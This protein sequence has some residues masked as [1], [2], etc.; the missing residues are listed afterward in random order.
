[1]AFLFGAS[2]DEDSPMQLADFGGLDDAL[3]ATLAQ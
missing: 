3:A 1:V 2:Q